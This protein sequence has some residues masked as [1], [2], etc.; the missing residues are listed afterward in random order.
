MESSKHTDFDLEVFT[1]IVKQSKLWFI[2][3]LFATISFAYL[4]I[5]YTLP[6]Y[7]S[8][9]ILQIH[10]DN[11]AGSV[12]KM[13]SQN[14]GQ[15]EIT[16][17]L[18]LMKS[19]LLFKKTIAKLPLA[20]QY[21][22]EGE[23]LTDNKYRANAFSI[24]DFS[25]LDAF[26]IGQKIYLKHNSNNSFDLYTENGTKLTSTPIKNHELF[27]TTY[28]KGRLNIINNENF[29][30][31]IKNDQ[32]YFVVS[33]FDNLVSDLYPLLKI[34]VLNQNAR[35]IQ[36]SFKHTSRTLAKDVVTQLAIEYDAYSLEKKSSSYDKIISFIQNQK[37]SVINKLKNSEKAI[38]NFKRNNEA[39]QTEAS[40]SLFV[41]QLEELENEITALTVKQSTLKQVEQKILD[42]Q[43]IPK[44]SKLIPVLALIDYN[45]DNS[46]QVLVNNLKEKVSEKEQ[47]L[48]SLTGKNRNIEN[49]ENQINLQIELVLE[50]IKITYAK[51]NK[52]LQNLKN[53][54][55]VINRHLYSLPE[56]ELEL[57]RLDRV[58]EINSK[59]YTMLLEKETEYHLSTAGLVTYNEVLEEAKVPKVPV[60]PNK[61]SIYTLA[62]LVAIVFSII[63][64]VIRY[65]LHDEITSLTDI[66]KR[67]PSVSVLGII[68]HYKSKIPVSQL[69][70]HKNPKSLI[71]EAFRSIRTNLEFIKNEKDSKVI[72]VTSTISGE[73]KTFIALN[74]GGIVAFSGKKVIVLDL[75][76][77][78]PKI[79]VG[80]GVNNNEGMSTLLIK[81]SNLKDCI[82]E[83]ELKGLDF[84]T[85]GP[86]PPNPSE[87]IINGEI[88][89]I[90]KELKKSYDTI[91]IDNPPVGL[92]TDGIPIIKKADFPIYVFKANYSKKH[93]TDNAERII[94]D[95]QVSKLA[96]ILNNIDTQKSTYGKGYGY[97]YTT[98][99]GYYSEDQSHSKKRFFFN[100]N[101][102]QANYK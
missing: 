5:H 35:T 47:L 64:V 101:K 49:L 36:I 45:F 17:E 86:I 79:H 83:S 40:S 59:F 33:N 3:F 58:L 38:Y 98:Y 6:I 24:T 81:K 41:T 9:L 95:H 28:L 89:E 91:I 66:T 65:L 67:I 80:F 34:K 55:K 90:V 71:T 56:K 52:L 94:K 97:G 37:D 2:F 30:E 44:I 74:L 7:E 88:D 39:Q 93:F 53:K 22:A 92:V 48:A 102:K 1:D 84:I 50:T 31:N 76:M 32:F 78:K 54:S 96:I 43:N 68:P 12:L 77:R 13:Y 26:I 87:L 23:I 15:D 70:I 21:F 61:K 62:F 72:A 99:G 29:I 18:E 69:I 14:G 20:I 100:K 85:A 16:S 25:I 75:D 82:N 57:A 60:S 51:N 27:E 46:L 42:Y 19:K 73:G 8:K 4:Y 63:F 11:E 10:K